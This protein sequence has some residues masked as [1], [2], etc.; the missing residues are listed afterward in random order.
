M[1]K[2]TVTMTFCARARSPAFNPM[3]T[4]AGPRVEASG[5]RVGRKEWAAS[6][7]RRA[8]TGGILR[9]R[10][11]LSHAVRRTI[12]NMLATAA[13]DPGTD[14]P[15]SQTSPVWD[16]II[17]LR[18]GRARLL[19]RAP[20]APAHRA[21]AANGAMTALITWPAVIPAASS[22]PKAGMSRT[23][24]DRMANRTMRA[25]TAAMRREKAPSRAV[26]MF[27]VSVCALA[28]DVQLRE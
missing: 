13:A 20:R 2:T 24:V 4:G 11:E 19:A 21:T 14:R 10:A 26:N 9:T 6:P 5:S 7:P 28:Y 12:A 17:R 25:T 15:G 3:R 18:K 27:G 23:T 22:V 8:S 16:S 1:A